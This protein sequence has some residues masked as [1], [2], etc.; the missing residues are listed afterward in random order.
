MV[1]SVAEGRHDP[2]PVHENGVSGAVDALVLEL[3]EV[4]VGKG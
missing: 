2:A 3:L 4:E 1:T